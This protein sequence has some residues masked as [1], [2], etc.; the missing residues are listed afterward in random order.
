[1]KNKN[2][3]YYVEQ[4]QF[5]NE[6]E[7][8]KQLL[9]EEEVYYEFILGKVWELIKGFGSAFMKRFTE[10]YDKIKKAKQALVDQNKKTIE[11]F[12]GGPADEEADIIEG[13]Y[14]EFLR[15]AENEKDPKIKIGIMIQI[16]EDQVADFEALIQKA[17]EQ[18][19]EVDPKL[20]E[21][22]KVIQGQIEEYKKQL[23]Q[24]SGNG[25][26]VIQ[27]SPRAL[28]LTLKNIF[29]TNPKA[30]Q[31]AILKKQL[32]IFLSELQK[33]KVPADITKFAAFLN[34]FNMLAAKQKL[35]EKK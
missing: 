6:L 30:K 12:K 8:L 11:A 33:R 7:H 32:G 2:F 23:Q 4:V 14:A 34:K 18:K 9:N 3:S 21:Q 22:V 24:L 1:V 27:D 29:E 28:M 15:E 17:E 5:N 19:A 16:L 31:N 20:R 13:N 35:T 26:Q 25:Q 10:E